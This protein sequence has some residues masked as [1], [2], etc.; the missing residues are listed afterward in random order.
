MEAR[1]GSGRCGFGG[2][3]EAIGGDGVGAGTG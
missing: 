1:M 3:G 2:F